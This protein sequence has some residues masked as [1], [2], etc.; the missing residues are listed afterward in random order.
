MLCLLSASFAQCETSFAD[1][2]AHQQ[3]E[4]VTLAPFRLFDNL[5]GSV[6][7][8]DGGSY[9]HIPLGWAAKNKEESRWSIGC[10]K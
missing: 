7:G 1:N 6:R 5:R 10:R 3:H 8:I 4:T 2:R 9:E